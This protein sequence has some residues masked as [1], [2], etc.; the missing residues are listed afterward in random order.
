MPT[1]NKGLTEVY[2]KVLNT[3]PVVVTIA[4]AAAM[5]AVRPATTPCDLVDAHA[6]GSTGAASARLVTHNFHALQHDV[7]VVVSLWPLSEDLVVSVT[8]QMGA[9]ASTFIRI[10]DANELSML[11]EGDDGLTSVHSAHAL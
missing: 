5:T 7:G 2:P 1:I 6:N 8:T 9:Y 3:G 11:E 10:A 4:A